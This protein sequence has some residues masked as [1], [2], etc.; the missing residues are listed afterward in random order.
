MRH[1]DVHHQVYRDFKA[2][3]EGPEFAAERATNPDM[4]LCS[5]DRMPPAGIGELEIPFESIVQLNDIGAF[6]RKVEGYAG[7]TTRLQARKGVATGIERYTAFVA[8][9]EEDRR[10]SSRHRN[11]DP[12]CLSESP[13][14]TRLF[15][16]NVALLGIGVVAWR[17][18]HWSEWVALASTFGIK[19]F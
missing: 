2:F 6:I 10:S 12:Y 1:L 19:N 8:L 9:P 11:D 18:T 16:L 3:V 15:L 14:P 13:S 7:G 4:T 17:T 5:F